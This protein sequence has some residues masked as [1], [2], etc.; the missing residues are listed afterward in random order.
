MNIKPEIAFLREQVVQQ[1]QIVQVAD[2]LPFADAVHERV[3]LADMT[4]RL[5]EL[6]WVTFKTNVKPN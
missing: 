4:R 3:V 6:L 1:T 2:M 5:H